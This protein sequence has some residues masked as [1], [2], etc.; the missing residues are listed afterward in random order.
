MY[1]VVISLPFQWSVSENETSL[2]VILFY[3]NFS[4]FIQFLQWI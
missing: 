1:L 2:F 3:V 4:E